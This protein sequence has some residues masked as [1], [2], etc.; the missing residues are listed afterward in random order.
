MEKFHKIIATF[1]YTGKTPIAPGT[2]GSFATVVLFFLL[3]NLFNIYILSLSIVLVFIVG[4]ISSDYFVKK[5]SVED[6][7]W[8]VIDEVS[9]MLLTL[10]PFYILSKPINL[11]SL[12][13][14]FFLFRLFDVIK[15]FPIRKLEELRGGFA[16]MIDDIGAGVY[17]GILFFIYL[18][19]WG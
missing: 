14:A 12:F 4:T 9:G 2:A 15:P 8:I 11:L 10:V 19:F 6:P 3:K 18:R 7:R 13:V 1:F 5:Y 16:I 17:A